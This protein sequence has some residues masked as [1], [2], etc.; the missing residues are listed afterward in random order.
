MCQFKTEKGHIA[1]KVS[2]EEIKKL[3]GFGIC[4]SCNAFHTT[5]YLIPVLNREYCTSCF[6]EWKKRAV[7]FNEDVDYEKLKLDEWLKILKE[8]S[9]GN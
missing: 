9:Y 2:L 4:D 6:K 3:G 5:G 1:I 8:E 7:F